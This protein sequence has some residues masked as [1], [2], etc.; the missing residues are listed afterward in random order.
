MKSA[1][2][3]GLDGILSIFA[4]VAGVEGGSLSA[5]VLV[6]LGFATLIADGISMGVG[7]ALSTH[8]ENEFARS[9]R[10]RESWCA[11]VVETLVVGC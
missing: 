3:G 11:N 10:D 1:I 4:C 7:D 8:A 6:V 9:E 2:F 5:R